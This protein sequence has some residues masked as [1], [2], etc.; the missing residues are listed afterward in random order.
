MRLFGLVP[1]AA[2]QRL[3]KCCGVGK[4]VRFR[5]DHRKTGLLIGLFGGEQAERAGL[6]QFLLTPRNRQAAGCRRLGRGRSLETVAVALDGMKRI[7]DI[8]G[9]RA[10]G[11]SFP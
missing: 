4:A 1:P 5:L 3:V 6:T 7:G 8:L 2:A 11:G 9:A 10:R